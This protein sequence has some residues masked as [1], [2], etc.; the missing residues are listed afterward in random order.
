MSFNTAL[1]ST[2]VV[3]NL[4]YIWTL[5]S[6]TK[7]RTRNS[8]EAPHSSSILCRYV[9]LLPCE[10]RDGEAETQQTLS[11][12]LA[13]KNDACDKSSLVVRHII[14][15]T[16]SV[17]VPSISNLSWSLQ[18]KPFKDKLSLTSGRLACLRHSPRCLVPWHCQ[19]FCPSSKLGS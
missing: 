8:T 10:R 1:I 14:S 12:T 11:K 16:L 7:S 9:S 15:P 6:T 5:R 19:L 4:Q 3:V 2:L 17:R 18:P 13:G